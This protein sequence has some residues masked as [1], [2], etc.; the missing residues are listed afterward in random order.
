MF[1]F[2]LMLGLCYALPS[3]RQYRILRRSH[4]PHWPKLNEL[5]R[6]G[7]P[8]GLTLIFEAMLFNSM[9]LLVGTFGEEQVAAHQVALNF[10][11]VTFMVPLGIAMA[12]TVRVGLHAGAGDIVAARRAGFTAMVAGGALTAVSAYVMLAH[13]REVASLYFARGQ[14]D[15]EVLTLAAL[16]LKVA[17]AFQLA[18]A[19]QVVGALSLRGLKDARAPLAAGSYW[20]AG[21]PVCVGL[22][23]GLGMQ[24]LG[25]WIGLAFGLAVAAIA[26]CGRFVLLTRPGRLN[27]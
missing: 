23:V 21:A 13:G 10:A 19:L 2:V 3:L 5:F 26:M 15:L 7:V 12:A 6:L 4:R 20:L 9:T 8:I 27:R 16:F 22:G 1:G 18:D 14:A 24:G 25:V 11:S 17:A